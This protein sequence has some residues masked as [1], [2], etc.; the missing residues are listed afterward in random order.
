M[1]NYIP[2]RI[3]SQS[4]VQKWFLEGINKSGTYVKSDSIPNVMP[5]NP[6]LNLHPGN[7]DNP[8]DNPFGR[9]YSVP[10]TNVIV[11]QPDNK[12]DFNPTIIAGNGTKDNTD[13]DAVDEAMGL[14]SQNPGPYQSQWT[15]EMD[16]Y[17]NAYQNRDPFS[18]NFN[19][20][21]LYDM[22]KDMYTQQGRMASMDVMGQ[23]AALTGGYGSSYA[24]TVGQQAYGQY[25]QQLNEIIPQLEQR[26]YDRYQ[27]EG[28]DLLD[29]YGI[30]AARDKMDYDQY[31]DRVG[32]DQWQ[33]S[34]DRTGMDTAYNRL[35]DLIANTGYVP[36]DEELAAA[37]MTKEQ[38]EAYK[39]YGTTGSTGS[40]NGNSNV[41]TGDDEYWSKQVQRVV[42]DG[43]NTDALR[44]RMRAA[45]LPDAYI[46]S[47]FAMYGKDYR[48]DSIR[49][50]LDGLGGDT[51][52]IE[53]YLV[54]LEKEGKISHDEAVDLMEEYMPTIGDKVGD[55]LGS[56][57]ESV[58][59]IW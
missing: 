19:D 12:V 2:P 44:A 29:M 3:A 8:A 43:G 36:T 49:K 13:T 25:L 11:S 18:Y 30:Y 32:D 55:F 37:G 10:S 54:G 24:Q 31:L 48:L 59:G 28:Q 51:K 26:A 7:T 4:D 21:A 17:L 34:F 40:G 47:V 6:V 57:W 42:E 52:A 38:A 46:D 22:Y 35:A 9:L 14:L 27:D 53:S 15:D 20:D 39:K 16:Y 23:A 56:V 1:S 50:E 45:G 5:T 58:K 41:S 33:D